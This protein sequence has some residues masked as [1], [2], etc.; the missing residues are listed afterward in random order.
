M[1]VLLLL[2]GGL[3]SVLA[4]KLLQKQGLEVIGITFSSPFFASQNAVKAASSLGIKL[5]KK[6]ITSSFLSLLKNP[7]HGY[8]KNM[9][10]CIDCHSLM[11]KEAKE[12]MKK[13]KADFLATGEVLGER[14]FSQNKAAL[15]EVAK[16]SKTEGLVLRP[17]SAK[18]LEK[19]IPEKEGWVRREHLLDLQ[20]RSR[21]KQ[22]ELAKKWGIK[23]Y[24][25]PAS[26][27][28]LTDPGYSKRLRA[29]LINVPQFDANDAEVIKYGRLFWFDTTLV[30]VGRHHTDNLMLQ[31]W[32]KKND[33]LMR[34]KGFPGPLTLIRNFSHKDVK[35]SIIKKAAILTGWYSQGRDSF[36]LAVIYNYL[37]LRKKYAITINPSKRTIKNLLTRILI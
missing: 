6:D 33:L 12:E 35:K 18:L 22:I 37:G 9:N 1:R 21:K 16:A 31:R 13:V 10:P 7:P 19:T 23:E 30:I 36:P 26:G 32:V 11:L 25:T 14:P 27:C 15:K 8:G 5:I 2:S 29:L 24:P 17:L 34:T 20:G 3:D 4:A 28:L